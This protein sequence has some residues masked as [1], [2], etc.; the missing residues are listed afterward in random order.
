MN[1]ESSENPI[2]S[3]LCGSALGI[4][5]YVTENGFIMDFGINLFK[6]C[7]FGFA[8]GVFGLIGKRFWMSI[9]A[10][11]KNDEL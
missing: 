5:S 9:T 6:V 2:I 11:N 1:H 4:I 7:F 3:I 8:G 10:K